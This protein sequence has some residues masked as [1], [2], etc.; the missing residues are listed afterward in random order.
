MC[1]VYKPVC[2]WV[3]VR[4]YMLVCICMHVS[5]SVCMHVCVC[6]ARVCVVRVC[7]CVCVCVCVGA[8]MSKQCI[9]R[10]MRLR[11]QAVSQLANVHSPYPPAFSPCQPF[12]GACSPPH[13]GGLVWGCVQGHK[14][15]WRPACDG[16]RQPL[17]ERV[18]WQHMSSSR[19][20]HTAGSIQRSLAFQPCSD[21]YFSRAW[22][23]L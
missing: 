22:S 7:V 17:T 3:H 11:G 18:S 12:P 19:K 13:M 20:K 14:A 16:R 21:L 5:M 2:I 4:I 8:N 10:G 1:L 6:V 15:A 23:S 9:K